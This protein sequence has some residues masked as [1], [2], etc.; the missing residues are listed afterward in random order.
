MAAAAT[1]DRF[2][3]LLMALEDFQLASSSAMGDYQA[4]APQG[5]ALPASAASPGSQR[6]AG[7]NLR[8]RMVVVD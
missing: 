6:A 2:I 3:D 7:A 5:S 1:A 4:G 8:G